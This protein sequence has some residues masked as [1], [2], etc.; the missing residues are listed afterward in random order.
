MIKVLEIL[1]SPIRCGGTQM[2]VLQLIKSLDKEINIDCLTPLYCEDDNFENQLRER[3]GNLF[4]LNLKKGKNL[5]YVYRP[6]KSFLKD[7]SYDIIHIHA[8]T[9]QELAAIAAATKH[10]KSSKVIVHSHGSGSNFTILIRL[11]RAIASISMKKHVDYYCACSRSAAEWKF[12]PKYQRQTHIIYNGINTEQF[13]FNPVRRNDIRCKL[14]ISDSEFVLGNVGRL[15]EI[16]NQSFLINVF[17]ESL[18][19]RPNSK[20]I[21]VGDGPDRNALEQLA[22]QKG[23]ADRVIFV[24][25]TND[26]AG[27]LMAMDV[28]VFPSK[29]EAFGYAA[30]EAQ[31]SGLPVIASNSLPDAVK[32]SENV[33]FLPIDNDSISKWV[34]AITNTNCDNRYKGLEIVRKAGYD[35]ETTTKQVEELYFS[36]SKI[37]ES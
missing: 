11:F 23:I 19:T 15:Y 20:L 26:V 33:V 31:A 27:Y 12:T 7:H 8:S 1:A 32:L 2:F 4:T 18:Q 28:F 35:L 16:K 10:N 14:H 34:D 6:I 25:N 29:H 3:G 22:K 5:N 17:K 21:L 9:I 30:L 24:G 36:S 37:K 13:L